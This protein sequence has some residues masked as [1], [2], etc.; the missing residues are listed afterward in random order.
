MK[1]SKL[2]DMTTDELH[3][4]AGELRR[5]LFNLRLKKATGQLEKPH[6]LRETRQDLARVLT[7]LGERQGDEREN[8]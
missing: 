5:A 2:R 8:S 4:E 1:T 7:L 6:K 3:R